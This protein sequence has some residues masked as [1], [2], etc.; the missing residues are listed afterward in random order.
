[1]AGH[2]IRYVEVDEPSRSGMSFH[3][4]GHLHGPIA[5][6]AGFGWLRN[7]NNPVRVELVRP[8]NRPAGEDPSVWQKIV[9]EVKAAVKFHVE[10]KGSG[11]TLGGNVSTRE[12][13]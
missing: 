7:P 3:H 4:S 13:L 12:I 9:D 2:E 8:R 6:I 1:M 11:K 5:F 10:H